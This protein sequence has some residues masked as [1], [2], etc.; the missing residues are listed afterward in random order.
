M[1]VSPSLKRIGIAFLALAGLIILAV[2]Y[3]HISTEI[4]L[5]RR[6][7]VQVQEVVVP[8]DEA[9]IKHGQELV[10]IGRC[11]ECHGLD[12]GGQVTA[13]DPAV[14]RIY[15]SNLTSGH[16][17]VGQYYTDADWVRAIRHGIG[18]DGRSLVITPAQYYYYLSN[19]DLGAV[20]A[21]IKSIPAVDNELPEASVGLLG[22]LFLTLFSPRDWLPAEKIDHTSPRPEAPEPALTAEYGK[23]FVKTR[24]CLVCHQED[25]ISGAPGG[26]LAG[27]S[28]TDFISAIRKSGDPSMSVSIRRTSNEDLKAMWQYLQSHTANPGD[29][30]P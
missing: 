14:G 12:L 28:E 15:A 8:T 26:D 16:G 11:T 20:I 17:G 19:R 10:V 29:G 24:T 27:W 5:S 21:Y 7:D 9:S 25:E 4:R 22:R 30:S 6:Y 2:I 13:D 23:Y 18:Q 1:V 3:T